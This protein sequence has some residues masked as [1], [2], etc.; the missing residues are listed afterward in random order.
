MTVEFAQKVRATN[1]KERAFKQAAAFAPEDMPTSNPSS[2]ANLL[3]MSMAS[4]EV[5][6]MISSICD[7]SSISGTKPGPIPCI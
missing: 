7:V 3:A 2:L 1:T 4:W 5:T 6:V